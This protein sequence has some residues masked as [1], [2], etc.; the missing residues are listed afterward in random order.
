MEKAVNDVLKSFFN[1]YDSDNPAHEGRTDF[2]KSGTPQGNLSA[3]ESNTGIWYVG[4]SNCFYIAVK[5][6]VVSKGGG[7]LAERNLECVYGQDIDAADGDNT[8]PPGPQYDDRPMRVLY[9]RWF[10]T[11]D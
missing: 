5:G 9:K 4:R 6:Q 11:P 10:T 2:D 3:G 7:V 8:P 1:Y